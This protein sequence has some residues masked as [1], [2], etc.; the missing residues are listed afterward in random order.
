MLCFID[1]IFNYVKYY[2][3]N[4]KINHEL[5]YFHNLHTV[6]NKKNQ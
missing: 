1:Y 6:P 4:V 5:I 3:N 2:F